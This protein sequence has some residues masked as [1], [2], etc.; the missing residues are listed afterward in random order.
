MRWLRIV[1]FLAVLSIVGFG[2]S[3]L[4]MTYV[5][6]AVPVT[7]SASVWS[8]AFGGPTLD[9]HWREVS[10]HGN[11]RYEVCELDGDSRL[12]ATST[13]AASVLLCEV[14][15]DSHTAPWLA[16]QWRVDRLI[17]GE[18]LNR[19]DGSD[20]AARLYVYFDKG[21]LPWRKRSLNYVWSASL[22]VGTILTSA[23]SNTAKIIVVESGTEHLGAWR[24]VER[25]LVEDY[26]RAF[27]E[28]PPA[29][30]AVGIMSDSDNTQSSATA[31][32]DDLRLGQS[33]QT[34]VGASALLHTDP[35]L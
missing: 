17:E 7:A 2:I 20:A 14:R 8:E 18:D 27:G 21:R 29:V 5:P 3:H 12:C 33:P 32:F 22:P 24:T 19:K 4:L 6:T 28:E 23:F 15:V 9:E 11:T 1:A 30:V 31:Y 35:A 26:R 13:A 10:L 25:N 34:P 16:W